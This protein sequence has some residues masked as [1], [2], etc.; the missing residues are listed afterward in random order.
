MLVIIYGAGEAPFSDTKQQPVCLSATSVGSASSQFPKETTAEAKL[1][2]KCN[3]SKFLS[4]RTCFIGENAPLTISEGP[5]GD[6]SDGGGCAISSRVKV[7]P[8]EADVVPAQMRRGNIY[9]CSDIPATE[10]VSRRREAL[11]RCSSSR[12]TSS[13]HSSTS[14]DQGVAT[15]CTDEECSVSFVSLSVI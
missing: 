8:S 14:V 13:T 11:I 1:S 5:R 10:C 15:W 2:A 4:D 12:C 6:S 7:S 9:D 3:K